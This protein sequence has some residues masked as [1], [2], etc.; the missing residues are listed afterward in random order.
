MGQKRRDDTL[1]IRA[2]CLAIA[3]RLLWG[4]DPL[5]GR[6]QKRSSLS[7]CGCSWQHELIS[8]GSGIVRG[9]CA[10]G[11]ILMRDVVLYILLIS[12]AL[13]YLTSWRLVLVIPALH[14]RSLCRV[15][16]RFCAVCRAP[17][18]SGTGRW[19]SSFRVHQ[20]SVPTLGRIILR[21]STSRT[22]F[23]SRLKTDN[24]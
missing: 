14:C 16:V 6:E 13:L 7:D 5:S 19:R 9:R 21:S 3:K 12:S 10:A 11:S 15:S 1:V 2:T 4:S 20:P 18:P 8:S 24:L 23:L 22:L 17:V